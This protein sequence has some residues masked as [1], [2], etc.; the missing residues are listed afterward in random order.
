MFTTFNM[1]IGL[2]LFA[3]DDDADALCGML[4]E[5]GEAPLR[6]GTV[7]TRKEGAVILV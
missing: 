2:M 6:I 3:A 7:V 5:A 1:G 4:R